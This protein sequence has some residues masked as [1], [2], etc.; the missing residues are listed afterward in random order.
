M[1]NILEPTKEVKW[2]PQGKHVYERTYSRIKADGSQEQWKDTVERV[3][4]GNIELVPAEFINENEA[5]ELFEL[6]YN[7]DAIPAGR[8]LWTSGVPG[9]Q[10][11]RNCHRSGWS[12]VLSEHFAFT[13][14][15]L[16]KGG[17]VG[18]NYSQEYLQLAAPIVGNVEVYFKLDSNHSD[19]E[20]FDSIDLPKSADVRQSDFFVIPDSREGWVEALAYMIDSFVLNQSTRIVFDLSEIRCRGSII[21]GFGGTASGPVPLAIALVGVC[22]VLNDADIHLSALEAME[23]DH[24]IAQCVVAGNIR[25]SARMSIVHWEDP[26][27]FDFIDCKKNHESHWTTNISVEI[28]DEFISKLE[29]QDPHA[30]AVFDKATEAMLHNG[31]PGFF[32]S[33]LASVGERNGDVRSTNPCVTGDTWTMTAGGPRQVD[34]LVGVD[35]VAIVDGDKYSASGFWKTGYKDVYRVAFSDGREL[36]LTDNHQLL[37]ADGE[38]V[39]LKDLAVGDT[40]KIHEHGNHSWSGIGTEEEGYL[41]GH[42][43]GDGTF[44]GEKAFLAIWDEDEGSDVVG[45]YIAEIVGTFDHRSDWRGWFKSS[46]QKRLGTAA[47]TNLASKFGVRRGFKTITP[48]IEQASSEMSEG[49]LRGLFDTD[50][51]VQGTQLKGV[52]VRLSNTDFRLL[53]AAQRMLLRLGINSNIYHRRDAGMRKLPDGQGGMRE[54]LCKED[55]DLIISRENLAKFSERVGFMNPVKQKKLNDALDSYVRN[56]NKENFVSEIVSIEYDG[57]EDVYDVTVDKV[58]CFDAN[59][60]VAHNCGEIAL[61]EFESCN[62]GHVN[63]SNFADDP[64]AA[65]EAFRLMSRFLIRATFAPLTNEKQAE[66]EAANRRIGVGFFGFQEWLGEMGIKY[67]KSATNPLVQDLLG[68]FKSN[69]IDASDA[70]AAELGIP[71][72]IKHTTLAPTG[73]IAKLP[74]TTEGG[75]SVYSRYYERRVRYASND[76]KLEEL[77]KDHEIEDCVYSPDTK[78]VVFHTKDAILEKLDEDLVEQS[79][80]IDIHD[81]LSV[82]KLIQTHYADNAVSFTVNF[83]PDLHLDHLR[84]SLRLHLPYLKGTTVMPDASRPQSPYTRVSKEQYEK[85]IDH[86]VG[87]GFDECAS[88]ACPVR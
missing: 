43:I 23:I 67:S 65:V 7:F 55:Y 70:Y 52:S 57:M 9:R 47:L 6:I 20:E 61:Q 36:R 63:L 17:G 2:G 19:Y 33:S 62:L 81:M 21:N 48:E 72:P 85:A 14:D 24:R 73:T 29:A 46:N 79:D 56:L 35:H 41:L 49:V 11:N 26:Q 10:F 40:V 54:Y 80:E 27:I 15:E 45:N 64:E 25:R 32:N 68:L 58:H 39:E 1:K 74:G 38:W 86:E 5:E 71:A 50:G 4:R 12:D 53:Q 88:G 34:D 22:E 3:V 84:L 78:V 51:S 77:A 18:A 83:N 66:V 37:T 69:V 13:F 28:D 44:G 82:Q 31:E 30:V 16:M 59:G 87:Q 8:H 42:L 75:H 60:V 76:P